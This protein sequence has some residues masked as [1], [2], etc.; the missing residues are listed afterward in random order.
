MKL[1]N[2]LSTFAPFA[3][4]FWTAP[5]ALRA[6]AIIAPA[7]DVIG[8]YE[9]GYEVQDGYTTFQTVITSMDFDTGTFSGTLDLPGW[10]LSGGVVGG[11]EI[12]FDTSN[13]GCCDSFGG[14]LQISIVFDG[15]I[16]SDG[17]LSG[18]LAENNGHGEW[19]GGWASIAGSAQEV[20]PEPGTMVLLG[21][22]LVILGGF[23]RRWMR[24]RFAITILT[25]CMCLLVPGAM[26]ATAGTLT[27]EGV[28]TIQGV[29]GSYELLY[30]SDLNLTW[31][32]Y[33][34]S[35]GTWPNQ[36]NW[37]AELIVNFD[38]QD[39][40]G[41][42]LASRS[43]AA[44]LYNTELDPYGVFPS[45][46]PGLFLTTYWTSDEWNFRPPGTPGGGYFFSNA[47][48][49][50]ASA[51]AVLPGDIATQASPEPSTAVIFGIS[52]L[53]LGCLKWRTSSRKG[54]PRRRS[55]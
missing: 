47:P 25:V 3:L 23:K 53:C 35:G 7:W 5:A 49:Y 50:F 24:G 19:Y 15:A 54:L 20:A 29:Q 51:V 21:T 22:C 12:T 55:L 10:T 11:S 9:I 16:A 45:A 27:P 2:C 28:G 41:W 37:A 17:T 32:D 42:S 13:D 40:S 18:S 6:D 4:L 26:P 39:V 48:G 38:G 1:R 34:H 36:V 43:D 14:P 31:L 52:L 44:Y 46:V 30:D 8:T 33:Q